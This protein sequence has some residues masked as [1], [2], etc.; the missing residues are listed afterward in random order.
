MEDSYSTLFLF[1]IHCPG[2]PE[3]LQE[4]TLI[5]S[6]VV[7]PCSQCCSNIFCSTAFISNQIKR[8]KKIILL[9]HRSQC[10]KLWSSYLTAFCHVLLW[11]SP[12]CAITM[13]AEITRGFRLWYAQRIKAW[14]HKIWSIFKH[15]WS[16]DRQCVMNISR[17]NLCSINSSLLDKRQARQK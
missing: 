17:S 15:L 14:K 12:H 3:S 16:D 13:T 7:L 11:P 5:P 6:F 8:K 4:S 2:H 9:Q 10:I 1:T